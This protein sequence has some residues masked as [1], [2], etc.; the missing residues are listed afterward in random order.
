M[1]FANRF[2]WMMAASACLLAAQDDPPGRVARLSYTYGSVSFQ[3]AGVDDWFQADFN[4]PLTTGDH[5]FVDPGGT[6]ELQIGSGVLLLGGKTTMDILNLDDSSVQLRLSEGTLLI[7]VRSL[8]DQDSFEVDTP[9]LSFSLLRTG[10]YRINVQPDSSSTFVTVRG[11]EGELN[12]PDQAFTVHAGEEV[13][14]AGADQPSYQS[15]AIPPPDTLD[16]FSAQ[17]AQGEDQLQSARYCSREM[18]GYQDLD[19]YGSWRNTP[20]Y[21]MVWAPNGTPG[22]WAPYHFGHWLWVDPWGWTWVDD[23]PWGF[24]P[25]HYGRWAYVGYWAW[26]PGPVAERPVYAPALVA[27]VGGEAVGG[28]VGWFALGPREVY[29]PSYHTSPTY[30]TRVNVSNTVIVNKVNITNVNITNVNYVNR[31]APGAVMAVQREAFASAKPVQSAAVVVRPEALRSATVVATASVAPTRASVVRTASPGATVVRPAAAVEARPV[32]AKKTPPPPPVPFAQRQTAL[33]GNAGRPLDKNQ[34]QQ[35]RQAQ[36]PPARPL[37]RQVEAHAPAPQAP[38]SP[39]VRPGALPTP[40]SAA[41]ASTPAAPQVQSSKPAPQTMETTPAPQRVA[42]ATQTAPQRPKEAAPVERTPPPQRVAPAT[43][44]APEH[45]KEAA[46]PVERMPPPARSTTPT[47]APAPAAQRPTSSTPAPAKT[48][49]KDDKQKKDAKKDE[50]KD[51]K[52]DKQ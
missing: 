41:P 43:Q 10:D 49:P 39:A 46:P 27:W 48:A 5:V 45:P 44:T 26:V 20:D 35:L 47:A 29:V 14:V 24:A 8:G 50:K 30:L 18:V 40:R 32:I 52:K 23:A 1:R 19:R 33:A 21:G 31:A 11:G 17:R 25:F 13:Q 16:R 42:P 4:R 36:P 3:P 34:V 12:G 2:I 38:A 9:N 15:V 6:A 22:G 7:R 51:E 37:V 28:G